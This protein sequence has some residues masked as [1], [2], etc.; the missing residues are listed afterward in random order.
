MIV[1]VQKFDCEMVDVIPKADKYRDSFIGNKLLVKG[2]AIDGHDSSKD[3]SF[4]ISN[5]K[6]KG[7]ERDQSRKIV[8]LDCG[9][10]FKHKNSYNCHKRM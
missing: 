1:P 7:F 4:E 2:A 10:Y 9:K 8:C 5:S 6:I 3:V